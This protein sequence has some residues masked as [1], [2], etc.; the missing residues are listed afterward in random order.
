MPPRGDTVWAGRSLPGLA[1]PDLLTA[2]HQSTLRPPVTCP[3]LSSGLLALL[4]LQEQEAKGLG[5]RPTASVAW[6][7]DTWGH[8]G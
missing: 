5:Q 3:G 4:I 1:C 7:D 8:S 2:P 6:A